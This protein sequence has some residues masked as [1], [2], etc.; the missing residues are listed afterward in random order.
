MRYNP[1]LIATLIAA[2]FVRASPLESLCSVISPSRILSIILKI[3]KM[4]AR[5]WAIQLRV[6]PVQLTKCTVRLVE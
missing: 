5:Q 4:L 6:V 2:I 3:P 1:V